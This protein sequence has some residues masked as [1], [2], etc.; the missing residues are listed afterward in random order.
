MRLSSH[1]IEWIVD[2]PRIVVLEPRRGGAIVRDGK[3]EVKSN[4]DAEAS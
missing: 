1:V 3:V 2:K 4:N